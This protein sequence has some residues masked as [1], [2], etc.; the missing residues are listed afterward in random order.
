MLSMASWPGLVFAFIIVSLYISTFFRRGERLPCPP[1]PPL[2]VALFCFHFSIFLLFGRLQCRLLL[3]P[4]KN[5]DMIG[6]CPP[7]LF[8]HVENKS[9]LASWCPGRRVFLAARIH[10]V[11]PRP[12]ELTIRTDGPP[13]IHLVSLLVMTLLSHTISPPKTDTPFI[14]STYQ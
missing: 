7:A 3:S 9:T 5:A 11:S 10:P 6:T 1:P 12:A 8:V 4:L 13:F 14:V 2:H